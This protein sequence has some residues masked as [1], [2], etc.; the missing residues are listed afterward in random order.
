MCH[1]TMKRITLV[2]SFACC[3]FFFAPPSF[4]QTA[5]DSV[6]PDP[7]PITYELSYPGLLPDSPFYFLK[8]AR[9][10]ILEFFI[11]QPIDKANFSLLQSDKHVAASL[12]LINQKK[13]ITLAEQAFADSQEEFQDAITETI[14]AKKQGVNIQEILNKLKQSNMKHQQV[15]DQI[16]QGLSEKDQSKF[17]NEKKRA[18]QLT[19]EIAVLKH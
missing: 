4:A 9:N 15:L 1:Y 19:K 14:S 5:T 3:F 12:T 11:G 17:T 18:E 13:D 6:F 8:E 2:F 7:T 10:T 16:T